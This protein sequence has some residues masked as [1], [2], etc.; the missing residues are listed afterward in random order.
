MFSKVS[1]FNEFK[2]ICQKK[3]NIEYQ[4]YTINSNHRQK[5][6]TVVFKGLIR[7]TVFRVRE[8]IKN[9]GLNPLY[10]A[11]IVT[12]TKYPIYR[13]TFTSETTVTQINHVLVYRNHKDLL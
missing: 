9:Q 13:V 11:E 5:T 2:I 4:T 10:C 12:H 1:D 7:L 3:K 6:I 8:S